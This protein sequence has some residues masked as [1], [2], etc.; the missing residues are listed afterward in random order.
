MQSRFLYLGEVYLKMNGTL[1]GDIEI[2]MATS[3]PETC[4]IAYHKYRFSVGNLQ[5][6]VE[7]AFFRSGNEQ[8]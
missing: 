6:C 1:G 8:A 4:G 7:L 2:Y 5:D 3:F